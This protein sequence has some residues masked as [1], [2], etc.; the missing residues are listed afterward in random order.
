MI[1]VFNK[2]FRKS[3]NEEEISIIVSKQINNMIPDLVQVRS[4]ELRPYITAAYTRVF[5]CFDGISNKYYHEGDDVFFNHLHSDHYCTFL[6]LV[7][8][9]AYLNNATILATKLFLLNKYLHGLDLYFSVKLPEVFMLVHPVG[10]VIG[11]A[12]YSNKIVI[13]QNCSIGSVLKDGKYIYPRFGENIVLY[14]RTSVIGECNIGNNVIFG[15]NSFVIKTYIPDNCLV[16][17]ASPNVIVTPK[18]SID[19]HFFR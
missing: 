4:E 18:P 3:I 5:H 15:A 1:N 6:Y 11:N 9:E 13:Y 12:E 2:N 19:I 10:S 7:S 16:T 14:S 8:N 17:G